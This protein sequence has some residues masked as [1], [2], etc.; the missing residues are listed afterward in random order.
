MMVVVIR[1]QS[2]TPPVESELS[3]RDTIGV[4][5]DNDAETEN[6]LQIP[7]AVANPKPCPLNF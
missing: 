7:R 5:A 6:V 4:A 3:V 1:G 2:V